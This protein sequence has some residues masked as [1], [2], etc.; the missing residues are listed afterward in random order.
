MHFL[1]PAFYH[2]LLAPRVVGAGFAADVFSDGD[3]ENLVFMAPIGGYTGQLWRFTPTDGG[4]RLS[5]LFR[6]PAFA[7]GADADGPEA[8]TVRL[9]RDRHRALTWAVEPVA[10]PESF[11]VLPDNDAPF[12]RAGYV[13]L[14][15]WLRGEDR[16][17]DLSVGGEA[18]MPTLTARG[19]TAGQTWLLARTEARVA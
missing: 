17:L 9:T 5:T 14:T 10:G 6:G 16:S 8:G 13:R 15:T 4:F 2:K 12:A 7:A 3:K 18:F 11:A 1:D 19:R